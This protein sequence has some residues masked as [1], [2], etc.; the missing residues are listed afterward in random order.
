ME[1]KKYCGD[2]INLPEEYSRFGSRLECLRKGFGTA[3]FIKTKSQ[4]VD[5]KNFVEKNSDLI[6]AQSKEEILNMI[7]TLR[8]VEFEEEINR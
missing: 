4:L 6:S 7:K 2:K 1:E 3:M 5:I 8:R